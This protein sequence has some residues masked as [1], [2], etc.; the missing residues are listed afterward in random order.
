MVVRYLPKSYQN[1][2]FIELL[3]LLLLVYS[4][5]FFRVVVHSMNIAMTMESVRIVSFMLETLT[6]CLRM[7]STYGC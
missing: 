3:D 1:H 4:F 6:F 5:S 7:L 2:S